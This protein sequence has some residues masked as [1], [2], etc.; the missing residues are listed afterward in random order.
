VGRRR[1]R[2]GAL[3]GAGV[4]LNDIIDVEEVAESRLGS[5]LGSRGTIGR[6]AS[7]KA[8]VL[9]A[10]DPEYNSSSISVCSSVL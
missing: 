4:E 6:V 10:I 5:I 9:V 1:F 7:V 3:R 8:R 2:R